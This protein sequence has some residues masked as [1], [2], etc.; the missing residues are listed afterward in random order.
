MTLS[1]QLEALGKAFAPFVDLRHQMG[2]HGVI[3]KKLHGMSPLSV[4]VTKAQMTA[5]LNAHNNLETII[6]TLREKGL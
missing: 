1:D 4:V 6:A 5:A 3:S 2:A